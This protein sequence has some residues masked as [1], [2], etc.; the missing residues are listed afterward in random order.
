MKSEFWLDATPHPSL[1][2]H[3]LANLKIAR[4]NC[5]NFKLKSLHNDE[6]FAIKDAL[7]VSTF[8][9][10]SSSLLHEVGT[11][12]FEHFSE[13]ETPV[14]LKREPDDVLKAHSDK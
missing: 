6:E 11:S 14:A 4:G 10:G 2:F 1:I 3:T 5:T 7:L 12:E 8:C 9:D 13:V